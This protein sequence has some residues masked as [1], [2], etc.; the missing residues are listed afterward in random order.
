MAAVVTSAAGEAELGLFRGADDASAPCYSLP[1]ARKACPTLFQ[2]PMDAN[3]LLVSFFKLRVSASCELLAVFNASTSHSEQR[4]QDSDSPKPRVP[5]SGR[6][7]KHIL[8]RVD[9][10]LR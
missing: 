6:V 3:H 10:S 9:A 2:H 7:K 1:G 8:Q 5:Q 4:T